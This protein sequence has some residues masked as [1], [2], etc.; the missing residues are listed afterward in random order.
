MTWIQSI[1]WWQQ[2]KSQNRRPRHDLLQTCGGSKSVCPV[3]I[4][5]TKTFLAHT[6]TSLRV[7]Y[8][9]SSKLNTHKST[10]NERSLERITWRG[11]L[12]KQSNQFTRKFWTYRS[13]YCHNL[14]Q[15]C[16]GIKSMCLFLIRPTEKFPKHMKKSFIINEHWS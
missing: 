2:V 8:C 12:I 7:N 3:L 14:P 10:I 1:N 9:W 11:S 4:W 6:R 5:P 15:T 16:G 13:N